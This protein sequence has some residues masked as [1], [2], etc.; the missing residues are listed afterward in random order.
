MSNHNIFDDAEPPPSYEEA[1]HGSARNNQRL[2][3]PPPPPTPPRSPNSNHHHNNSSSSSNHNKANGSQ[4]SPT[5][6]NGPSSSSPTTPQTPAQTFQQILPPSRINRQFPPAFNLYRNA[7]SG[8]AAFSLGE[9][10]TTPIYAVTAWSG[11]SAQASLVLHNGPSEDHPPLASVAYDSS[12]RR[13]DVHLPPL[14]GRAA[15]PVSVQVP[16]AV[17]AK[18]VF[19]VEIPWP[20]PAGAPASPASYRRES[21][22]WRRSN[23]LAI[24][25]LGGRSQGWK[26]VR[27][28]NELP[29]GGL[30]VAG[31]GPPA[32]DGHEVVAI[33][34]QAVMSMS[35]LWKF[36]FTGTGVSGALGERWAVMAVVTGLVIWD[37]ESRNN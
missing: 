22:E 25:S 23:S 29:P 26:L 11:W 36:A 32:G 27:L 13:M 3:L 24:S 31:S 9:H 1:V 4:G 20:G 17:R 6:P 2:T 35:K 15:A 37:Q 33:C 30:T 10:Q 8:R 18:V 21:F 16:S 12:G 5:T 34:A 19:S 7:F 28:S 14:P